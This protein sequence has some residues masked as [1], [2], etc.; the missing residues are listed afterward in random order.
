MSTFK[1][2]VC[3]SLE[4]GQTNRVHCCMNK[5]KELV[6]ELGLVKL[7]PVAL[8]YIDDVGRLWDGV[9]EVWQAGD[10]ELVLPKNFEDKFAG[11]AK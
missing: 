10:I 6:T 1:D 2:I 11:G 5:D 8:T 9:R 3:L 7:R 4:W